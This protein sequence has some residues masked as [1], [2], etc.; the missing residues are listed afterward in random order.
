MAQT[1]VF[2]ED[3]T[4]N[5]QWLQ[6]ITNEDALISEISAYFL[7]AEKL[8][9]EVKCGMTDCVMKKAGSSAS[10]IPQIN[11]MLLCFFCNRSFHAGCLDLD[12]YL[13]KEE[14]VPWKCPEC[15]KDLMNEACQTYYQQS[16]YAETMILRRSKFLLPTIKETESILL[17]DLEFSK[18]DLDSF[19]RRARQ[20]L[21]EEDPDVINN[22]KLVTP[23]VLKR[24]MQSRADK[25]RAAEI[26]ERFKIELEKA[27]AQIRESAL[28][29]PSNLDQSLSFQVPHSSTM[30]PNVFGTRASNVLSNLYTSGNTTASIEATQAQQPPVQAQPTDSSAFV[31][32]S[33]HQ[34]NVSQNNSTNPVNAADFTTL[35]QRLTFS[36]ERDER[37]NLENIRRRALPKIA[38]FKGEES[39]WLAFKQDVDRYREHLGHDEIA[40]KYH[41][42]SALKGEAFDIVRDLFDAESLDVIMSTLKIAFGDEM[43]MVRNRGEELKNFKFNSNLYRMDAIKLQ[44]AIQSYFAA[45]RYANIGYINTNTIAEA[46]FCQFNQEDRLRCKDFYVQKNPNASTIKKAYEAD[47]KVKSKP[48]QVQNVSIANSNS[49]DKNDYKFEIKDKLQAPYVGYD[50]DKVTLVAKDC[51]FCSSK[52]HYAVQCPRYREKS[53]TE[54]LKWIF[55]KGLCK[56]CVIST[57]HRPIDCDLKNNCGYKVDR[58]SRCCAKHHIT[59]HD[60][61]NNMNQANR[62]NSFRRRRTNTR[63]N[64]ARANERVNIARNTNSTSANAET[65]ANT[66]A[67]FKTTYRVNVG[68]VTDTKNV[69][70]SPKTV[71]VFRVKLWGPAGYV[72]ALV[73]GDSGSEIT[74]MRE[75][76]REALGIKGSPHTLHLQWADK[77]TRTSNAVQLDMQIQ[78]LECK[79]AKIELKNCF[80]LED[81]QL[82]ER[83]LDMN[84]LREKFP[85]LKNIPF[86]G[87]FNEHPVMLIGAP[88]AHLIEGCELVEGGNDGPIAVR[89]RIG[90]SVYGGMNH[91]GST[92]NSTQLISSLN[93]TIETTEDPVEDPVPIEEKISN[94]T[95]H[96]L[97]VNHFSVESLGIRATQTYLTEDEKSAVEILDEEVK[98]LADG[99]VEAPLVWK[100]KNKVIPRLPNN[101]AAVLRRQLAEERKLL[102]NPLHFE[103]YNKNVKELISLNYLRLAT[104]DDMKRNWP[105]VWYLPMSLVINANKNPPK[106]R[107]VYDASATYQG[108][109]LNANLLK[110]PDLLVN[111][112][113][114]LI[115]M[116]MNS[117]AF[118]ADVKAMFN[119]V[120]ICQRDQQCQRLLYRENVD[121]PMRTLISTVMLF[122]PSSSPFTSQYIKNHTAEKWMNKYPEA[123]RTL[124][125]Y[126]YMDDVLTSEPN[127]DKALQVAKEC[128]EICNSINWKLVAFQ[129]N[130]TELLKSLPPTAVK[131][132]AIPLLEKESDS[133][134]TKVLG[135]QW[136]TSK[137][138]FEFKLENNIFIKLVNDFDQKPSKR[139]QAS[140]LA[141]IYDV[142][143]LISHFTIRGKMLLQRS[144][145]DKLGWDDMISDKAAKEWKIWLKQI[146]DIAKLEFP[147]RFTQLDALKDAEDIHLHIFSDAGAEAF[148]AVAYLV[149]KSNH[150]VESSIIMAKAKVTPLRLKTETAIKEMPRLELMAALIAARLNKT[151]SNAMKINMRKSYWCDSEVVLRWILNPNQKLIKYAVAPIEEI[152]ELTERENWK[153][154]PTE[155]NVADLCTK[156]K[157]FDFSCNE[158]IW[159]KG[160]DFIRQNES[161]WPQLPNKLIVDNANIINNIYLQK[162]NYSTHVLPPIN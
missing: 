35:L 144:W 102:K 126:T 140:T 137:D 153:F 130:S 64:T 29:V 8:K 67:A 69:D 145:E 110:G 52:D 113:N 23:Y 108:T 90:W 48:Y 13:I 65:S 136:N 11:P 111:I 38:E 24:V 22:P 62:N 154:V 34:D 123:A 71:K 151:I 53:E 96:K 133:Y 58:T 50:L 60:A 16:S 143:G 88:H 26:S 15:K 5:P 152:L 114:P 45:C 147:R 70:E 134:V 21:S 129:S 86:E 73:I 47:P 12:E 54:R 115:R 14:A 81:L 37:R 7:S 161:L 148:G 91:M 146:A 157:K 99:F 103:A 10:S 4:I 131:Q 84:V 63:N 92:S 19:E 59:I 135:C 149:I 106:M 42:K 100:R 6:H 32:M 78:S 75:D 82:P 80:A 72:V 158:S 66:G 155:L 83:T 107:N 132:E 122:G 109:S 98:V 39:K 74:L 87:Y 105:N 55:D 101:Y 159:M 89:T 138:C 94:E 28:K 43:R 156:I 27:Q 127:V 162:L 36:Q 116:R 40:L 76:L 44:S 30:V 17:A 68:A 49:F 97:L 118:T 141:R 95:L 2:T 41:I 104:D 46:I 20:I 112:I 93:E 33:H 142:L 77:S 79:A 56:N 124:I 121:S 125:E 128:I 9:P 117:I 31:P 119:M 61:S 150:N 1:N 120:K 139:D 3:G 25:K 18:V 160:P 85:H 51:V 57:N